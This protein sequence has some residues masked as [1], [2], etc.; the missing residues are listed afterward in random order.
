[1]GKKEKDQLEELD[2]MISHR[3]QMILNWRQ[4]VSLGRDV[5]ERLIILEQVVSSKEAEK[6]Q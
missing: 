4:L 5:E 6:A 2:E 3:D 1:M